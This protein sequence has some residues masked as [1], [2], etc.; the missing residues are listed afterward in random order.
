MSETEVDSYKLA[1]NHPTRLAEVVDIIAK[2][3]HT[4]NHRYCQ[5]I[6]DA[7]T[8]WGETP[9]NIKESI[10]TG[11]RLHLEH[12]ETTAKQSHESWL[13]FKEKEGG[14]KYGPVKDIPNKIH[15]CL[16]P[17]DELPERQRAKDGLFKG[18]VESLSF[19]LYTT[20]GF[21]EDDRTLANM[22]A[23]KKG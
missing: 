11:V 14:W 7:S 4:V 12:P 17:Y 16:V 22:G 21:D 19:L 6:G 20:A 8:P 10:R 3:A 1:L 18:V 13:A 9:D 23:A 2:T 15:N 5:A